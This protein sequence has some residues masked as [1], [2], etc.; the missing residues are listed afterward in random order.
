[1]KSKNSAVG[2]GVAVGLG[3]PGAI[4]AAVGLWIWSC[5][6]RGS[7][8]VEAAI[9]QLKDPGCQAPVYEVSGEQRRSELAVLPVELPAH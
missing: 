5:R 8:E 9:A 3:V 6:K 1:M 4:G 7:G 2:I